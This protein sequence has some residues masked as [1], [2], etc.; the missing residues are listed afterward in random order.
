M[1]GLF[2]V[3]LAAVGH[4]HPI[5]GTFYPGDPAK[6]PIVV[7]GGSGGGQPDVEASSLAAHGHPA[8]AL[9]YFGGPGLPPHLES[10]P[11]EYFARAVRAFDRRPGVDGRRT[12]VYGHSRGSESALLVGSLW[13]RLVHGVIATAPANKSYGSAYHRGPGW[14]L[15]GRN[16][17]VGLA[18]DPLGGFDRKALIE[19]ERIRGPVL[20]GSGAH[21]ALYDSKAYARAIVRRLHRRRFPYPVRSVVF[22]DAG[23][24]VGDAM[25]PIVLRWLATTAAAPPPGRTDRRARPRARA[26]RRS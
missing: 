12:V 10:I 15:H 2:A 19:V 26:P 16:L 6:T 9:T 20:L 7:W 14:T 25:E 11:L 13:P 22:P 3:V 18:D 24:N 21:D 8:F 17:P 5:V 4:H 1:H 23:H